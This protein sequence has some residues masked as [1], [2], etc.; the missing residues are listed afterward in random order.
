MST[1]IKKIIQGIKDL[2]ERVRRE[3]LFLG[4][5]WITK[6]KIWKPVGGKWIFS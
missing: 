5:R 2:A 3:R 6:R 4:I 1:P